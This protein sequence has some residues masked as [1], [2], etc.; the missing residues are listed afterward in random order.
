MAV[1]CSSAQPG[2]GSLQMVYCALS[3]YDLNGESNQQQEVNWNPNNDRSLG[4][5][6]ELRL[7]LNLIIA[8]ASRP[9]TVQHTL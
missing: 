5:N 1:A 8:T 3:E 4:N 9:N 7:T 2:E 6:K